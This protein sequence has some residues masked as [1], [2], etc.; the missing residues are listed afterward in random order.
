[1]VYYSDDLN[2]ADECEKHE[3]ESAPDYPEEDA[4]SYVEN[5]RNNEGD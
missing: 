1:M 2:E 4:E 3:G 5:V